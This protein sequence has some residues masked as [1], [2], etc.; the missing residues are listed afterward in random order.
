MIKI[1]KPIIMFD[2]TE[3]VMLA[4]IVGEMKKKS[5]KVLNLTYDKFTK[6][7]FVPCKE[8]KLFKT[9]DSEKIV[10]TVKGYARPIEFSKKEH[11]VHYDNY[12][13]NFEKFAKN[14]MI[15]FVDETQK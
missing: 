13:K 11:H 12:K 9:V 1:K 15:S 8:K 6:I 10:L 4:T 14:N 5:H 7:A 3:V 2:K